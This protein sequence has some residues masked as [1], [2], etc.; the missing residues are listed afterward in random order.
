M[1]RK[2][3]FT[4]LI[5]GVVVVGLVAQAGS[6]LL[7]L[8]SPTT[9]ARLEGGEPSLAADG[10]FAIGVQRLAGD[11][12]PIEMTVWYPALEKT[13]TAQAVTYS[14]GMNM[15]GPDTSLALATYGGQALVGLPPAQSQGPFPLVILSHGFAI[16]AS[17]YGWLAEHL[18]SQGFVVVAPT[19]RESLDP[20]ALWRSTIER[21]RDI[22]K[23]LVHIGNAKRSGDLLAEL[24]DTERVAVVGHSYGGYTALAMAG[25][26]LDWP[27]FQASCDVE[28]SPGEPLQFLCD[29]LLPRLNDMAELAG[30]APESPAP[31]PSLS[32]VEVDAVITMAGDAA[33]FGE[34][35]LAEVDVP[36]L[37][38]GGTGDTD[39]PFEWGT[40]F[41]YD[42]VSSIRKVEIS[43]D[44]A[45]HMVLAGECDTR[46][47]VFSLVSLGF[48]S[49][50]VWDTT[51]IHDLVKHYATVFLSAELHGDRDSAVDLS[52]PQESKP[53]V[54][55]LSEGY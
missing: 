46:R 48:C 19:H 9:T 38:I 16:A 2:V 11:R 7:G 52:R 53:G 17:S 45:G 50:P 23:T 1:I 37:A 10:R 25:A 24:I 31:W 14:Y 22:N 4:V 29:A 36:V 21:P 51:Q 44:G 33:M 47:R 27:A 20:G 49:D 42:N 32:G 28:G 41:S 30:V 39:S 12:V 54:G 43:L 6:Y 18:A 3:A 13:T 40:R 34:E 8:P 5:V 15:L 35:G 55:F 26:R